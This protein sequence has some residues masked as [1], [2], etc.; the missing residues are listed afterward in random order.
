MEGNILFL[1]SK[2]A[3]F[4]ANIE[5]N[6][7]LVVCDTDETF[8]KIVKKQKEF[9][10]ALT[11]DGESWDE[12]VLRSELGEKKTTFY[13]PKIK[14]MVH[15]SIL[16]IPE[17]DIISE[18]MKYPKPSSL[19][20]V[21]DDKGIF[22]NSHVQKSSGTTPNNWVGAKMSSYWIPEE[23]ERYKRLLFKNKEV[24]SFT[25]AAYFF[26]GEKADFTVD[27]RLV[28]FNGDLC[29]WVRVVDCQVIS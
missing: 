29:R 3:I 15:P 2:C 27:A 18:I 23:L 16:V 4:R 28:N 19:I 10:Q 14:P 20:R 21:G 1:L 22:T 8:I 17:A 24:V 5:R 13:P 6:Q 12:I 26:T 25:Y 11:V 7:I 9:I